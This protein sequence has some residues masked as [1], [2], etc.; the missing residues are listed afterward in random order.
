MSLTWGGLPRG[1]GRARA[2]SVLASRPGR[3]EKARSAMWAS[4][5]RRRPQ[6]TRSTASASFQ[7]CSSSGRKSRRSKAQSVQSVAA[8]A[9]AERGPPSRSA[10]SP[11]TEPARARRGGRCGPRASDSRSGRAGTDQHHRG[12]GVVLDEDRRAGAP[13]A[14]MRRGDETVALGRAEEGEEE[15]AAQRLLDLLAGLRHRR[16]PLR[17]ARDATP[18]VLLDER[19]RRACCVPRAG[20]RRRGERRR[21]R[22]GSP[23]SGGSGRSSGRRAR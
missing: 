10:I 21:A 8:V 20:R 14:G 4:A 18:S 12:A 1:P 6:M 23:R 17:I 13:D 2:I 15:R 9:S 16:P 3:S 22:A 19:P 5:L 11:K 7:L